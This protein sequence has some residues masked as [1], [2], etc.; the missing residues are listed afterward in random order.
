MRNTS[1]RIFFLA[2]ACFALHSG[3]A[4]TV[5]TNQPPPHAGWECYRD[6]PLQGVQAETRI[7]RAEIT[8]TATASNNVQMAFGK[9]ADKDGK[10]PAEETAATIGWD[11]G[12]WFILSGDLLHRFTSIPQDAMAATNRTLRMTVRVNANGTPAS[13]SFRDQNGSAVAFSGLTGIPSW[14]SPKLWD[15]A[16]LTA[17]G[18][19][20]RDE[21]AIISFVLDGTHILLR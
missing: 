16:A 2:A 21:E 20:V 7:F 3:A 5:I 6:V 19:D 9:D 12:A 4:T 8:F 13:L 15:M 18:W 10:L 1:R 17:R 11:R 14:L